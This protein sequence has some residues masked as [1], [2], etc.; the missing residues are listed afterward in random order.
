MRAPRRTPTLCRYLAR[1][2]A[3][4]LCLA[5]FAGAG[6]AADLVVALPAAIEA[7]D[8]AFYLGEYATFE[9]DAALAD[10]ASMA[11]VEPSG[12]FLDR[13]RVIE[14][15]GRTSLAGTDVALR[16]PERVAVL[17]ES[18]VAAE[19]RTMTAWKWRIE[20]TGVP[21]ELLAKYSAYSLPPKVLPGARAIAVKLIDADGRRNNKQ[22]KARWYQPVVYS[23]V[24]LQRDARID[25][26]QLGMRIDTIPMG[27]V[28]VWAP[29]QLAHAT[30]RQSINAGRPISLGDVEEAR[31]VKS[32]GSVII[33]AEVNGLGVEVQGIALQRGGIGDIIKVKNLASKKVILGKVIDVGKVVV[34]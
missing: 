18:P 10:I 23:T 5:L 8:G 25:L 16:V 24:P 20:V 30:V 13:E 32:G 33:R 9:G 4:M 14:A 1:L 2:A 3:A 12:G 19:L 6:S 22:A 15:L 34:Q 29:G 11:V 21:E 31:L 28:C 26:A 7:R 17:P 27:G